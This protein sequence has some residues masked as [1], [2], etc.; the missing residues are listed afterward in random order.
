MRR[1]ATAGSLA[2][3]AMMFLLHPGQARAATSC[4][5]SVAE[6]V[7]IEPPKSSRARISSS[8]SEGT[9]EKSICAPRASLA[10]E[11]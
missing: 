4:S 11:C 1:I 3:L 6:S 8:G 9:E 10:L 5:A 7:V 2:L